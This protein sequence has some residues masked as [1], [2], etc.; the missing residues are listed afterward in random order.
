MRYDTHDDTG[1]RI[2]VIVY[3][4]RAATT[5]NIASV[6]IEEYDFAHD[7]F[8]L[9]SNSQGIVGYL[10]DASGNDYQ[11]GDLLGISQCEALLARINA[12]VDREDSAGR[13]YC[14]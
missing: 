12:L 9:L 14:L 11:R 7:V 10:S 8:F 2:S 3:D 6:T 4:E 5:L 13:I 1:A